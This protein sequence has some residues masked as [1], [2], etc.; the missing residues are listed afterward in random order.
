MQSPTTAPSPDRAAV[1]VHIAD[2]VLAKIA[3]Y[4]TLEVPGV[5]AL[6][7]SL[8]RSFTQL[9]GRAIRDRS[10]SPTTIS[11]DGVKVDAANDPVAVELD[12]IVYYG[13]PCIEVATTIQEH[14]TDALRV[15]AGVT[16]TV[17]VNIVDL[18]LETPTPPA[19]G[20]LPA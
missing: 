10:D 4:R 20:E 19:F 1:N 7:P 14:V 15:D 11:T 5:A 12:V 18:D 16:P 17:T 9:P 6:R 2:V 3:A 8:A 13:H